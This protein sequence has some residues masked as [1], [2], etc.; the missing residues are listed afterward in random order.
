MFLAR[1]CLK[2]T[3]SADPLGSHDFGFFEISG[4]VIAAGCAD[5]A[6][7]TGGKFCFG[8]GVGE[9]GGGGYFENAFNVCRLIVFDSPRTS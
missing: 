6:I 1:C 2:R 7:P 9:E 4:R 8:L 3:G 5:S